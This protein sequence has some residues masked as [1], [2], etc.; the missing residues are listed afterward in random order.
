MVDKEMDSVKNRVLPIVLILLIVQIP[1]PVHAATPA[2]IQID[3]HNQSVSTDQVVMFTAVVKD[4][5]G[6]V[7]NEVVNWSVSSGTIDSSGMFTP[8]QVGQT[9]VTATS[10]NVNST[11][12]IDVVAGRAIGIQPNFSITEVSIDDYVELN[13][14]L[15]DR[16]GNPVLGELTWRC[17]NGEIDYDNNTWKPDVIGNATMRIMY[18]E[19]EIQV[20]FNVVPGIPE[21][22]DLPFGLTVQSGSTVHV[23][24]TARDAMGNE[25]EISKAGTLTWLVENGSISQTGLYFGNTPGLWNVTV[26]SSS[27]AFGN[28]VI[29]VLPAQATGL[30]IEINSSEIRTG[31]P[32]IISA[33]RTD[34]LG[35]SG[36]IMLPLSNWTVPTGSLAMDGNSVTWTPSQVGEWTIAVT[37]QGFSTTI[38][39]NVMQ[40]V[41]D[42][43]EIHLSEE[44]LQSGE[45]IIASLLAYDIAGNKISVNGAWM[46]DSELGYENHNSWLQLLPGPIGNY[47]ISATWFDNETQ[48]VHEI[49]TIVEV[50]PGELSRII[51]P[52]SGTRVTS[53]GVLDLIPLFEDEYGNTL[54]E[55]SVN[56]VIDGNDMTMEIL[57]AGNK[58]APSKLGMHEIR[59]MTQGVFAITNIEV[60]SGIARHITTDYDDGI[61][62]ASGEDIEIT[63]STLDVHGNSALASNVEFEIEDPEGIITP[64]SKGDGIWTVEG[65]EV[66]EWNLRITSGSATHDIEVVVSPGEAVRLLADI[67]AQNPEEGSTM[68]V[69][70]YAIDQVGN[71][72]DVPSD[73]IDIQCT[74][75]S[76]RHLS[77]DT[78]EVAI[79]QSGPSQSCNF[80]WNDLVAQRFFDVEAVLFGGG[81]GDS[82]T[83]LTMVSIII[84]LFISIMFVLM[85]RMKGEGQDSQYW[86]DEHDY[87]ENSDE[88]EVETI[89]SEPEDSTNTERIT[90]D[91]TVDSTED[92]RAKLTAE[93]KRTGVMQAAPGTE[94]GKTGWYID[95]TGELTSWL[96]SESGEWTRMS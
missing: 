7:I 27:G 3:P 36:E 82:N 89:D 72:V 49:V 8:G 6:S 55:V 28:G 10:G 19:I 75:G 69:R 77:G 47:S 87:E 35:N 71:I 34:I 23:I 14:T 61:N 83:A 56:W 86:E 67:P 78:Y 37:D 30:D 17:Q 79:D 93:A 80:Y 38:Q 43:I 95:S 84:F 62:V 64:S 33:I 25:V 48:I 57:L 59:A 45:S 46:L 70:I 26:N 32:V 76:V 2:S 24:P 16:V 85:R 66:G 29:R 20:T 54:H 58:W 90:E 22:L 51:L 5:S 41:I 9:I 18:M 74:T 53:D 12:T 60:V 96:V 73:E 92:I 39:V 1:T 31:S 63:I 11:T 81:L 91:S 15:I 13:A 68:V 88:T 42:G 94:Q 40:G 21:S 52:E 4:S 44:E 65:G 50:I